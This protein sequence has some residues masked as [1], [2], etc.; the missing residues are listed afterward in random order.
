VSR[1]AA[2]PPPVRAWLSRALPGHRLVAVAPLAGG[3]S[4]ENTRVTTDR[5]GYV[6]RR[7]R[8]ADAAVSARTCAVEAALGARL[9]ATDVPVPEVIAADPEG[10]AAGESLLLARYVPGELVNQAA[11]RDPGSAAGLGEA[12]G[13]ALAAIGAVTFERG[14]IFTGPGLVPSPDGLPASLPGFV[15][16]CLRRGHAASVLSPA[17]LDGLR[18]LAAAADPLAQSV[19]A[20]RQLVHSDYNGKN[21]LAV[22]RNGRWAISAVLDWEFAFSGSPLT[23]IGNMLRFPGAYPG[24]FRDGFLAGYRQSGGQ[25]P[26]DWRE[27]SQALDLYAL[28]DFLTRPPGHRYFGKAVSA[29]RNRLI[30]NGPG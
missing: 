11:A 12:A 28:A 24:G 20:A 19:A 13:R 4:N 27:I 22:T 16:D 2:L 29:L 30:R 23:D 6:L 1:S 9:A 10:S 26:P 5:G 8:R 25:L 7:Y 15:E 18:A 14:G 21:L 3:Y 17:E